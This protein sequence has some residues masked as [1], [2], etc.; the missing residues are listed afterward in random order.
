MVQAANALS[1]PKSAVTSKLGVGDATLPSMESWRRRRL[2]NAVAVI[3]VVAAGA[4]LSGDVVASAKTY[5]GWRSTAA[6]LHA[7]QHLLQALNADLP[8]AVGAADAYVREV[9]SECPENGTTAPHNVNS[10]LAFRA[11]DDGIGAAFARPYATAVL[12]FAGTVEHLRWSDRRLAALVRRRAHLDLTALTGPMP[13]ICPGLKELLAA[14]F[15]V[16]PPRLKGFLELEETLEA[17]AL[18][19]EILGRLAAHAAI[20]TRA[21]VRRLARSEAETA[22]RLGDAET[23]FVAEFPPRGTYGDL[24]PT[25]F[26]PGPLPD[27]L[28]HWPLGF[29]ALH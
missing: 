7:E 25:V 24:G 21:V 22:L 2:A 4:V 20:T 17:P 1:V 3:A 13:E 9:V 5:R 6:Y 10:F 26:G 15:H 12:V 16:L 23:P 11:R 29:A 27:G 28:S 14:G 19:E 8:S 18:N